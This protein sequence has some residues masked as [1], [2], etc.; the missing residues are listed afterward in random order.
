[1]RAN[2]KSVRAEVLIVGAGL[3]G[4]VLAWLLRQAGHDVLVVELCDLREKDKLCG[5][6]LAVEVVRMIEDIYGVGPQVSL[7]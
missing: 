6:I 3:A 7:V 4:C 2:V 1:M 5:G